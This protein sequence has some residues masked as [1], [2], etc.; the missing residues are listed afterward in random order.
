MKKR[1]AVDRHVTAARESLAHL[2]RVREGLDR[3]AAMDGSQLR[4]VLAA[5]AA[6]L[7]RRS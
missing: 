4:M 1:E 3:R 6:K 2:H 7:G 5:R